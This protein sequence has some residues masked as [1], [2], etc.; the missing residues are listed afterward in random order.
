VSVEIVLHQ[1]D[2]LCVWEVRVGQFLED[3]SII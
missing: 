1:A 2:F 3:L